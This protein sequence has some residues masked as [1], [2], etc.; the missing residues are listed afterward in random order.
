MEGQFDLS[1]RFFK[2]VVVFLIILGVYLLGNLFYSFA[3]LPQNAPH[4]FSVSGQ[5]KAYIKPDIAVV[6]LGVKTDGLKSNDVVT[7]NNE[8][9]NAITK[10]IKDAGVDEKDIQTTSYNLYPTYN[11]T[12]AKGQQFSGYSLD[13]QV[14][15]KIRNFDKINDVLDGATSNGATNVSNLQFTV[16]NPEKAVSE[17]RGKAIEQAKQKAQDI[18]KS[19]G[20]S[21]LKL[22]NITENYNNNPPQPLYG[23]GAGAND[24][25]MSV[26]PQIQT[27]Q[28]EV[29]V[30]V[31]LIYR[32]R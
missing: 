4:D 2:L 13:Q 3:N 1:N 5:G 11:W 31:N 7:Q 9:M 27:G 6:T 18:A 16:D 20:L 17:A 24:K 25:A 26:A 15:V 28:Q 12:Q 22:V 21:L 32:V 29:D 10:A 30:T 14:T 19:A 8:K 23:M